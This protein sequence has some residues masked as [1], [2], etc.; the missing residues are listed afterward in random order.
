[1]VVCCIRSTVIYIISPNVIPPQSPHPVIPPLASSLPKMPQCVMF[2]SLYPCVLIVQH[3]LISENMAVFDFLFLCQFAEND[4][5]QIHPSPYKGH[6]LI[7]L[8]GS[9]VFHGAYVPHFPC[10]VYHQWA[11]ELVPGLCYC[12]QCCSEHICA[13]VSIIERFIILWV[14]T[15]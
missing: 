12:K 6:K 4:G 7:V 10:P 13:C 11:F 9:I 1:M 15:Q 3:P 5:F 14:Y 2:P 8:Y